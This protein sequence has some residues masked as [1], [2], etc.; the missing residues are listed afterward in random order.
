[1]MEDEAT[2]E[3]VESAL[4]KLDLDAK[5]RLLQGQD[6]WTLPPLPEI[7]LGSLVM[8]DGPVGVRGASWGPEDPSVL[9][10]SP[11]AMA[12]SW[13]PELIARAGTLLA[14]EA[15]RKG[16]HLLLAPTVN[17]HRTPVG[18]RHFEAYSEDPLLTGAI[19][20][21][22]VR[23]VQSGGVGATVKHFVANDAETDRMF[24]DNIV[25]PEALREIYLAPF[26][27]IVRDASPWAIMSAYN[28]VNGTTMSEHIELLRGVLRDEWGFDGIVV[29]DWMGTRS[30]VG[31]ILGGLD[32][33]MPGPQSVYGERLVKAVQDGEVDESVVDE[34]VRHVLLL[35]ARVGVLEGAPAA[36]ADLPA[37]VDGREIAHEVARR[38]FVLAR[39]AEVDGAPVLPITPAESTV[40][41]IGLAARDARVLGGGSA[42]VF[43]ETVVSPLDGLTAALPE[44]TLSYNVGTVLSEDMGV[45]DRGFT[46]RARCLTADG[47]LQRELP[48]ADGNIM[49]MGDLPEGIDYPSLQTIEIL[50]TFTPELS[51]PHRFGTKGIGQF[52]LTVD[53]E[54]VFEG[55]QA[56]ESF[57]PFEMFFGSP[58]DR[59]VVELEAGR[60]VEVVLRYDPMK[61]EG[62]PIAVVSFSLGHLEPQRDPE[63]LMAEA[64]AA[65]AQADVAVVVVATTDKVESEGFDRTTLALPGRQDELVSRVVAANPRTVVIVNSGAPVEMPWRDDVAAVLLS[66]FPGQEAG[67]ALAEVLTGAAEPGGRLP[68]TWPATL[69]DCPVTEVTPTDGKLVYTED[70]FIGY[71][72]WDRS[73]VAPAYSFGHGLGYTTWE[74]E[75][76]EWDGETVTVRVRNTGSRPGREV[77]QVYLAPV[78]GDP[79]RPARALAGFASVEAAAGETVTA[80]VTLPQRAFEAWEETSRKWAYRPGAYELTVGGSSADCPLTLP[81]EAAV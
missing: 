33:A 14:Q 38:S 26:E 62:A 24:V 46:L 35:A 18:G 74:Y 13:D 47:S 65:A 67:S 79:S 73:D 56:L 77:V 34:A 17:M 39:N 27:A 28:S 9:L 11:T 21:G 41:L 59:A 80:T 30:T 66:W 22:F 52:T 48:L 4:A 7:G 43:P 12:A 10:P 63:E 81:I 1:M 5:A 15:R 8:S 69:A 40:A 6:I 70:L 64:E 61:M 57:D 23:G 29:S 75:D 72:A 37:A 76:I 3:A 45:A 16:V 55:D 50:G 78:D 49:W 2:R 20:S 60:P 53:G 19:G 51:G 42:M 31:A 36:V 68:T 32:V 25:S 44:G 58:K 71:R 54:T